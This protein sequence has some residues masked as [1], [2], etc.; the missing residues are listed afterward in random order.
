[1]QHEAGVTPAM[2]VAVTIRADRYEPLHITPELAEVHSEVF[3]ELKPLP[4]AGYADVITGPA[5]RATARRAAVSQ[6]PTARRGWF[7]WPFDRRARSAKSLDCQQKGVCDE[8]MVPSPGRGRRIRLRT[9]VN[10][11]THDQFCG[12]GPALVPCRLVLGQLHEIVPTRTRAHCHRV[13]ERHRQAWIRQRWRLHRELIAERRP[14]RLAAS[15]E[16]SGGFSGVVTT[17]PD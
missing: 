16:L 4:A 12:L 3:N 10:D 5:R 9:D 15:Q 2:I 1:V 17:R 14:L 11:G 7:Q 13:R 8:A 6:R